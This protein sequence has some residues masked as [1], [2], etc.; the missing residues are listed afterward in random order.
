MLNDGWSSLGPLHQELVVV[1]SIRGWVV[2]GVQGQKREGDVDKDRDNAFKL[3][4]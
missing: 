2:T 1:A 4:L 3:L